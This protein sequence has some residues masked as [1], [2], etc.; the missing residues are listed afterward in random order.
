MDGKRTVKFL[1]IF[2]NA[3]GAGRLTSFLA[4]SEFL[5]HVTCSGVN[6]TL[7]ISFILTYGGQR[8]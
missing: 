2:K 4:R 5:S 1:E 8:W 6:G 3:G 7:Y